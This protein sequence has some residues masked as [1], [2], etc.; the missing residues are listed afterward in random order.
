[1]ASF[2]LAKTLITTHNNKLVRP[3][4]HA[5]TIISS[6]ELGIMIKIN[7]P[8]VCKTIC[9]RTLPY[10]TFIGWGSKRSCR[11]S[12]YKFILKVRSHTGRLNIHVCD[13]QTHNLFVTEDL[14]LKPTLRNIQNITFAKA[15]SSTI[16]STFWQCVS[17]ISSSF[18]L[19]PFI[20]GRRRGGKASST[21]VIGRIFLR[22]F[23]SRSNG[24]NIGRFLDAP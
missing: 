7:M 6:P 13:S 20:M 19:L 2:Y 16:G 18:S 5:L 14:Y 8:N 21:P 24:V 3:N 17:R 11:R 4:R 10:I 23:L 12:R 15:T 1:M 22:L 9:K